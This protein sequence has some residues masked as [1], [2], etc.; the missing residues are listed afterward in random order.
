QGYYELIDAPLE[1]KIRLLDE[2]L[3]HA[4]SQVDP[5]QRAYEL[6]RIAECWLDLGRR[7]R[8]VSLLREGQAL[9]ES[10]PVPEGLNER[11]A[12]KRGS[13]APMLARIDGPAALRLLN[14]FSGDALNNLRVDVARSLADHDPAEAER[15]YRQVDMSGQWFR[16]RLAPVARMATADAERAA[17]LARSYV[18]PCELAFALGNVAYALAAKDRKAAVDLLDEAYGLLDHADESGVTRTLFRDA[19]ITAAALLPVAEKI[20]PALVEGYFWRSLSLRQPWPTLGDMP[21]LREIRVAELA[22]LIARYDRSV[23][24]DLQLPLI[25]QVG[26]QFM[27]GLAVTDPLWAVERVRAI[28]E[29]SA[30]PARNRKLTA[31]RNLADWLSRSPRGVRGVLECVYIQCNLRD[32]ETR[33]DRW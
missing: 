2:A 10:L 30:P 28:P 3:I 6:G 23:A 11:I 5:G 25:G 1:R 33:D 21:I 32:P 4:R 20:D 9:A 29:S 15:Q 17:R 16:M 19:A 26:S 31:L 14:G 22:A 27:L 13:F 18:D 12:Y 24:R 7:E 8:G